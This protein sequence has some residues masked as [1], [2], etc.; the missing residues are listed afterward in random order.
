VYPGAM[1]T[2]FEH[3]L[4]VMHLA[5]RMF[6]A[7]TGKDRNKIL[8]KD[9]RISEDEFPRYRTIVRLAGLLHDI[10]HAPFSHAGEE[11][12]PMVKEGKHYKHE[13]YSVA[14]IKLCFKDLIERLYS[15]LAIKIEE[16]Y[17]LIEGNVD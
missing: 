7:I 11:I 12:F 14:I 4:G 9:M 2:R 3:S 5:T 15:D 13:D 6:N 16:V 8:L 1:H 17:G 10:G